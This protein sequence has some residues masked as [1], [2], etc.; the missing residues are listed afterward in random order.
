MSEAG[1]DTAIVESRFQ[2]EQ[3][4]MENALAGRSLRGFSAAA[5][6]LAGADFDGVRIESALLTDGAEV[7]VGKFRLTFYASRL[8][9]V[10]ATR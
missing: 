8:D 9:L 4:A 6:G 1:P 5:I 2:L 10:A 7:Q 3:L